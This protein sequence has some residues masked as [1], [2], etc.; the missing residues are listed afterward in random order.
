MQHVASKPPKP[1]HTVSTPIAQSA[2][3]GIRGAQLVAH[4]VRVLR[5]LADA[6][7]Q[8]LRIADL[9]SRSTLPRATVSRITRALCGE[10]LA[11]AVAGGPRYVLGPLAFELGLSA[12][13]HHPL[14]AVAAASLDR[15]AERTGDTCF[16]MLRSGQDALC[17]DRREGTYPVKTLTIAVGDR[18]PLGAAAASIALLMHMPE[19]ERTAYIDANAERIA[20]YGMLTAEVVKGLVARAIGLGFALNANN[21]IPHVSAVGLAI[22]VRTGLPYAALSVSALTTRMMDD[23]RHLRVVEWLREESLRIAA[24]L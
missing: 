24:R 15:L 13:R 2:D 11:M 21:I 5:A 19:A 9:V 18:R 23:G 14:V 1:E 12:A 16:L 7:E 17:A 8:G 3:V 4:T 6:P 20:R 22:P 10:Q